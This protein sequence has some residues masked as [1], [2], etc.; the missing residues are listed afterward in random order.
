VRG[1]TRRTPARTPPTPKRVA[2]TRAPIRAAPRRR[3]GR[4]LCH[5]RH[6]RR[7]E[8][9]SRTIRR[10]T[11]TTRTRVWTIRAARPRTRARSRP[12]GRKVPT[13]VSPGTG[14]RQPHR[15]PAARVSLRHPRPPRRR[16]ARL[17]LRHL[18][19]SQADPQ[20]GS[21]APL[22]AE[23]PSGS[24]PWATRTQTFDLLLHMATKG[25]TRRLKALAGV[26]A[27]RCSRGPRRQAAF[28]RTAFGQLALRDAQGRTRRLKALP[29]GRLDDARR[30]RRRASSG[31]RE[32]CRVR[33]AQD[34]L[35]GG[36]LIPRSRRERDRGP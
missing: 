14:T 2:R 16:A 25:R 19:R 6:G 28:Y 7:R 12:A 35:R 10:A 26:V 20:S 24:R 27:R 34:L 36:R 30:R 5:P 22:T 3:P 4:R 11:P 13:A 9:W 33:H 1:T 32:R 31:G 8:R 29:G 18:R 15:R 23:L 17:S 21:R